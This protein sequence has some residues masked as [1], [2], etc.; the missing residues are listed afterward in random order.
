MAEKYIVRQQRFYGRSLKAL[1]KFLIRDFAQYIMKNFSFPAG[2]S[3][4]GHDENDEPV[5]DFLEE[6]KGDQKKIAIISEEI[7]HLTGGRYYVWFMAVA[8]MEVGYD[9]TIYTNQTPAYYDSFNLYKKPKLV[10]VKRKSDIEKLDVKADIYLSSPLMGNI[11]VTKLSKKYRKPSFIMVF[12][13]SPAMKHFIGQ[14]YS[15]W[16]KLIELARN[17]DTKVISLCNAMSEWIYEWLNKRKDQVFP[18]YPCINSRELDTVVKGERQDYALFISRIVKHKK[19]DDVLYA[20]SKTNLRLKV[21]SSNKGMQVEKELKRLGMTDRVDFY[22]NVSEKEKFELLYGARAVVSGSVFE[23]FGMWAAE[24]A[25]TG[26][27]LVCYEFPTIREIEKVGNVKNFY[28]AKYDNSEDLAL[29]L[30]KCL[31]EGKFEERNHSFDFESMIT[32]VKQVFPIEPRIGVVTIALNEEK[33][34]ASSLRSII[35]HPN[36]K[37]VAVVEGAVNLF[38]HAA[39]QDGMSIDK[40]NQE[41]IKVTKEKHGGKIVFERHGWA[42]DKSELRNRALHLLGEDI[43]Y[44]LVVDADEIWDTKELDKL[45]QAM[46]NKPRAGALFFSFYHF[47]KQVDTIAV[48]GQWESQMF[49]C[50]KFE[51]KKLKWKHHATPVVDE[52]G[53]FINVTDGSESLAD[54]HV[55]HLGYLKD[56][57]RIKEKLEFYT[58]RDKHLTVV[59]TWSDWEKGKPT[60]PTHGG[61]DAAQFT[62]TYPVEMQQLIDQGVI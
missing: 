18:I 25:A 48:G 59:N 41:V 8:L 37:K 21:V 44:V 12:D 6:L 10:L 9:V 42:V 53:K 14:A 52:D 16:E 36:V 33:F 34:I 11:A 17:S 47:W 15:G 26:T 30:Q 23:G 5:T 28:F 57:N 50:F 22:M 38:A 2:I 13:P 51:N 1:N 40:T 45:V 61:G 24:A 49:R 55:H 56:E 39:S 54:V 29:T 20:V 35:K 4:R 46:K 60:Q 19:F 62:G 32:R 58:K 31:N 27:P 7:G 3:S 43:D